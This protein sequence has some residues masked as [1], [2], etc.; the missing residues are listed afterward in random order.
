MRMARQWTPVRFVTTKESPVHYRTSDQASSYFQNASNQGRERMFP[1]LQST[2]GGPESRG[3]MPSRGRF[4]TPDLGRT[5]TPNLQPSGRRNT[6][7]SP[8]RASPRTRSPSKAIHEAKQYEDGIAAGEINDLENEKRPLSQRSGNERIA[9][10]V[11]RNRKRQIRSLEDQENN[12]NES[13]QHHI[14]VSIIPQKGLIVSRNS[15]IPNASS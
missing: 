12:D 9:V 3:R 2:R 15:K 14:C 11:N 7:T 6:A 1:R 8:T 5:A 10:P 13:L 4:R